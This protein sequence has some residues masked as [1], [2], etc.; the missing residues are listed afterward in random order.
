M[1]RP[2]LKHPDI[3]A[4]LT[5]ITG[6]SRVNSIKSDVCVFSEQDYD[7][8]VEFIDAISEREYRNSG[9]CQTCQNRIFQPEF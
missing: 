2:T 9:L 6:R 7:H 3:D 8:S 1:A 4:L 5:S